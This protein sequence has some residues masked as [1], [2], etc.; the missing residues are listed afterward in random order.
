MTPKLTY[1]TLYRDIP[2]AV[3]IPAYNAQKTLGRTLDSVLAQSHERLEVLVVD[4]GS[5]DE[6]AALAQQYAARDGRVRLLSQEN[7]G[8]ARARNLGLQAAA[9]DFVAFVDADDLWHPRKIEKQLAALMA[10]PAAAFVY[11]PFRV[12]D[13]NDHVVASGCFFTT[14]GRVL[15]RHMLV[16]FVGNGSSILVRRDAALAVGGYAADMRDQGLEGAE[17]YML[18]LQLAAAHEVEVVPEYLVGYRQTSGSMSSNIARMLAAELEARR[19]IL[20]EL[21]E[22]PEVAFRWGAA[23]RLSDSMLRSLKRKRFWQATSMLACALRMD[24]V[25]AIAQLAIQARLRALDTLHRK[26]E[27]RRPAERRNFCQV[28]P[29]AGPIEPVPLFLARRLQWLADQELLVQTPPALPPARATRRRK[30]GD[31]GSGVHALHTMHWFRSE[32]CR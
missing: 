26:A 32:G 1:T 15:W 30:A 8:V 20:L 4:D 25:G 14:R 11:T 10:N 13:E 29:L 22:V 23:A 9:A 16:N 21:E 5:C 31:N 28:D 24:T 7:G 3:V 19:R 17:D 6:T 2:V 18:Q 27:A 12:I